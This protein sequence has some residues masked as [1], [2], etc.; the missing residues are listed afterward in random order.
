[1]DVK[2]ND[3]YFCKKKRG[4]RE[5]KNIHMKTADWNYAATA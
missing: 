4:Q 5:R 3:E 1:M 2:S